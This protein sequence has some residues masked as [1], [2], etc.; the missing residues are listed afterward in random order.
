QHNL[1]TYSVRLGVMRPQLSDRASSDFFE[2]LRQLPGDGSPPVR[3][4][5]G[6]HLFERFDEPVSRFV[7]DHRPLFVTQGVEPGLPPLLERQKT[8]EYET[9]GREPA[10]C[11]GRY[12]GSG[13]R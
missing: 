12:E 8:L 13:A 9:L 10:C 7:E 5:D 2:H 4:E 6:L 11:E 3:P 1:P